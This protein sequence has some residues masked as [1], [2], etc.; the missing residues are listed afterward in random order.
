MDTVLL[1]RGREMHSR[2]GQT[3]NANKL[4]VATRWRE[5]RWGADDDGCTCWPLVWPHL[6]STIKQGFDSLGVACYIAYSTNVG[7]VKARGAA[8]ARA[9]FLCQ[10]QLLPAWVQYYNRTTPEQV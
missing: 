1:P 4:F 8:L 6:A 10:D 7:D 2:P 3:L 9:W 5:D